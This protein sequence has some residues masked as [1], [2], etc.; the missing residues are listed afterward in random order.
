MKTL[1]SENFVGFA[2]Y[3]GRKFSNDPNRVDDLAGQALLALVESEDKYDPNKAKPLVFASFVMT[4]AIKSVL[5]REKRSKR[6]GGI[7]PDFLEENMR[8]S[9]DQ[10]PTEATHIDFMAELEIID[11]NPTERDILNRLMDGE[12]K[13]E[14]GRSM[15]FDVGKMRRVFDKDIFP[16]LVSHFDK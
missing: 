2:Y 16:K 4:N 1:S 12:T 3:L 11:L 7:E 6:G 10:R 15:G 8:S 5:R 9:D 13:A 14:I